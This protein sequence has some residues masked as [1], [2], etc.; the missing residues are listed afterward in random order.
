MSTIRWNKRAYKQLKKM[1]KEVKAAVIMA[2][3]NLP[4]A[5]GWR[6]VKPIKDHQ[7]QYRLRVGRYWVFFDV[8]EAKIKVYLIQEVKKRD[9]RTY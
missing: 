5:N 8:E 4:E 1:P 7:Y 6:Q 3:E 2:V 9:D